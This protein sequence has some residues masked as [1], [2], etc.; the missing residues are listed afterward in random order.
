MAPS[1]TMAEPAACWVLTTGEAGM[2]SQAIGL[3]EAVGLPFSE[4]RITLNPPWSWLPGHLA[5]WP[6]MGLSRDSDPIHPPWP[7]LVISCGRRSVAISVA[8]RRLS[9][10]RSATVHIQ[11]P[12]VPAHFFDLVIPMRHDEYGGANVLPVDTA[13][14]RLTPQRLAAARQ[15]W[16]ARLKPDDRPLLGVVLGG[17]NRH[18]RWDLEPM[19]ALAAIVSEAQAR[20]M[21]VFVTPSRRTGPEV[22]AHLLRSFGGGEAFALWDGTDENPYFGL[23][24]LADRL[25]VTG[26][27]VSMVSE[28]LATGRQVHVLRLAGRGRR[29]E[30]FL[31]N[32]ADRGLV[33]IVQGRD[34]DW[35]WAGADPLDATPVAAARVKALLAKRS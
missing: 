13:L 12:Q 24:A 30:L 1:P 15:D 28:C 16:R 19:A 26:D 11:D 22:T 32:L 2:R 14:H 17:R 4:K 27:S 7:L 21:R 6:L 8:L 23:M 25:L 3:A 9:A 29:H 20:G 31:A 35:S 10:G 18:Y 5:P 33:S 34:L